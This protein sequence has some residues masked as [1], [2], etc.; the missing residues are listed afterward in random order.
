M[1]LAWLALNFWLALLMTDAQ[2]ASF[3]AEQNAAQSMAL[4]GVTTVQGE[5]IFFEGGVGPNSFFADLKKVDTP[6]GTKFVQ[7]ESEVKFFPD[8]MT[9]KLMVI[10]PFLEWKKDKSGRF[11]PQLMRELKVEGYWKSGMK[12]RPIKG[13]SVQS[14]SESSIPNRG[15]AWIYELII[16]DVQVPLNDHLIVD[17]FSKEKRIMRLAAYL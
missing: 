16:E 9:A 6:K 4:S 2:L 13:F 12:L 8:R 17:V 15:D 7:Q 11:D 14:V 1:N 5:L 10:H 3:S